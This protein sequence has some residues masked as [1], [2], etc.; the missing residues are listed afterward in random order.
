MISGKEFGVYPN[1]DPRIDEIWAS[2]I[3]KAGFYGMLW[4]K[5]PAA[6][7][8]Q[9]VIDLSLTRPDLIEAKFTAANPMVVYI[10]FNTFIIIFLTDHLLPTESL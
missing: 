5:N 7:V 6:L 2:R 1:L 9:V 4:E 10:N 3:D 8:R